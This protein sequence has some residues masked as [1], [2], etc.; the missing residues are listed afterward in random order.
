MIEGY[1]NISTSYFS[2]WKRRY[3]ILKNDN[4]L[5]HYKEKGGELKGR[6][7]LAVSQ[8]KNDLSDDRRFEIDSGLTSISVKAENKEE[9]DSWINKTK[10]SQQKHEAFEKD[11]LKKT[12]EIFQTNEG[13]SISEEVEI[14]QSKLE[15]ICMYTRILEE[16]NKKISEIA[17]EKNSEE[18]ILLLTKKSKV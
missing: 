13:N 3:F 7:H 4:I 14:F 10:L 12:S 2:T 15:V 9:R 11:F 6:I 5:Y 16:Y 1:L 17:L 18:E 8:T